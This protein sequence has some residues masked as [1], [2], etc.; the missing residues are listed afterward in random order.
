[1]PA[2]KKK[3]ASKIT[4][5]GVDRGGSH[6]VL[7]TA[8]PAKSSNAHT[9]QGDESGGNGYLWPSLAEGN[10]DCGFVDENPQAS[11]GMKAP[12]KMLNEEMN[13]EKA[14]HA[15]RQRAGHMGELRK[16]RNYLQELITSP[17]AQVNEVEDG[18]TRYEEAFHNFVSSHDNYLLYEE[19][20]ERR[21]LMIDS[22]DNQRDMKL[23]LD[24]WLMIGEPK[25]KGWGVTHLNLDLV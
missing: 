7:N 13:A 22:Y 6:V 24:I 12:N 18:V 1:M 8:E 25:G 2:K 23:Q 19:D 5:K 20:E 10:V 15:K 3:S 14:V 9:F 11:S 4:A 16:R 21:V 17:D